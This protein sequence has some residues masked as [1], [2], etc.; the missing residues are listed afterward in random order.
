MPEIIARTRR[1]ASHVRHASESY[2]YLGVPNFRFIFATPLGCASGI[3]KIRKFTPS[4]T[5]ATFAILMHKK[6]PK[7]T[8]G[9]G[10]HNKI[11]LSNVSLGS[12]SVA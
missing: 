3:A 1:P 5:F 7:K 2:A 4:A 8:W 10:R 12:F 11:S 9:R 6:A